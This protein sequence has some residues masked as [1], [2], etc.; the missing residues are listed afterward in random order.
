M[1]LNRSFSSQNPLFSGCGVSHNLMKQINCSVKSWNFVSGCQAC[2]CDRMGSVNGSC[3]MS[4]GQCYCKSG[5]SGLKCDQCLPN[6]YSFSP[7]GCT[8]ELQLMSSL[9]F[10]IICLILLLISSIHSLGVFI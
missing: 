5:V 6:Y 7:D 10:V 8:S 9:S 3:D 2:N 1:I 4:S